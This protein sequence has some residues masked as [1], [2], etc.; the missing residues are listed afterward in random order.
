[1]VLLHF[2][3][4]LLMFSSLLHT[5]AH[6]VDSLHLSRM[7]ST[8]DRLNTNKKFEERRA[9]ECYMYLVYY[10]IFFLN[11]KHA[12]NK[13]NISSYSL[14]KS[15]PKLMRIPLRDV[16]TKLDYFSAY[17]TIFKIDISIAYYLRRAKMAINYHGKYSFNIQHN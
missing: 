2:L 8:F 5:H 10:L 14:R 4:Q 1:M 7:T 12:C 15:N 3:C 9:V 11:R 16:N 6:R 13:I 17:E